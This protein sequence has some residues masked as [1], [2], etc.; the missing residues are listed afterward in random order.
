MADADPPA[1]AD[2]V[3]V[4]A[5]FAGLCAARRLAAAGVDVAVL[6]ASDGVGGRVRTDVIDGFRCDRGFQLYNPA[7]PEGRR[8][9]DHHALDLRP[10]AAGVV[11]ARG[12]RRHRVGDP[13]RLPSWAL[14]SALAPVGT[15]LDTA[16]LA[17]LALHVATAR[18]ADLTTQPDVTAAL[19]LT[20]ARLSPAFVE[21]VLRPFLAGVFL[22]DGLATSR[23]FLD[24]VLRS[25][26]RGTPAVPAA[27][28]AAIP[29]QLAAGLPP[30]AIRLGTA[31][32]DVTAHGVA[33]DRGPVRA[34]AV[35]VA[36]DPETAARL[37]P[38]VA[39]PAMRAVTTYYHVPPDGKLLGGVPAL[40]VDAD[41]RGPVVNTVVLTAA[42]PSYA[43][44]GRTL[45]S[46]SVLGLPAG[47][48]EDRVRRHLALLYGADTTRWDLLT[49]YAI[50]DAL[51]AA[52]PPLDVRRPVRLGGGRY[53]CG[54]HRDTP[55][56]Q[57][58]MV[59]GRRAADA[60][61]ADL[62]I[63]RGQTA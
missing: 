11:V 26:A 62:G 13:R 58:A 39:A 52:P 35:V 23:R 18:P 33:T 22:E 9:L 20:R 59:S 50:R 57:G 36:T 40:L 7:Y 25:F 3:V 16:R 27:G 5:G 38:G 10:F 37:L 2:A 21:G 4:G 41:R 48:A 43:P 14:E 17:R 51:P 31:V 32:T 8:L 44:A 12:H 29:G 34:R 15:P 45:V 30:G 53:V 24:L 54:D 47:D 56:I 42:A 61:L 1:R 19:A 63:D 49:A 28:M 55:S 60:V 46:T 6:E